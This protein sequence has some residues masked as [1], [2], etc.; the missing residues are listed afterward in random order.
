MTEL[1]AVV[2][3]EQMHR[4]Q[5]KELETIR[6]LHIRLGL[7]LKAA[8]GLLEVIALLESRADGVSVGLLEMPENETADP[9][10]KL[11][12]NVRQM[13]MGIWNAGE[14]LKALVGENRDVKHGMNGEVEDNA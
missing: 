10:E 11:V 8:D 1:F 5:L 4:I 7:E 14:R 13:I 12:K 2:G 3:E 6:K 9:S